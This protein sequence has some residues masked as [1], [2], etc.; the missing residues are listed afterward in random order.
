MKDLKLNQKI[1]S[2]TTSS[3]EGDIV[4]AYQTTL[5]DA[6]ERNGKLKIILGE[7]HWGSCPDRTRE[8]IIAN[9]KDI[10]SFFEIES[11]RALRW[12][13]EQKH[14]DVLALVKE[15]K[16]IFLV[17][18]SSNNYL[19]VK[20]LYYRG[21]FKSLK[22]GEFNTYGTS[23][24]GEGYLRVKVGETHPNIFRTLEDACK[25]FEKLAIKALK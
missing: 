4:K 15:R 14:K 5:V 13:L 8:E 16:G 1:L 10:K 9:K 24:C 18:F 11:K 21:K 3:F 23:D 12:N 7:G 17:E 25:Q 22:D 2:N 6:I 20:F 19:T